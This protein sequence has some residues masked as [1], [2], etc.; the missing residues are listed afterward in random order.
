MFTGLIQ[1]VGSISSIRPNGGTRRIT[2][3]AP[4]TSRELEL[5]D[6]IAVS[7]VCLT[8]VEVGA[9]KSFSADLARETEERTSFLR[10]REGAR[11]NLEL[12]MQSGAR[13]GGHIVQG[14]V[15][16][17]GKLLSLAPVNRKSGAPG[18][19]RGRSTPDLG[20]FDGQSPD[21]WLRIAFPPTLAR[22]IVEKGSITIEGI[23]LTVAGVAGEEISIAIIPHTLANTNL[24]F[25]KPGDPLNI[26][27][28]VLAKY[29]E[30]MGERH[31]SSSLTIERLRREGF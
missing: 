21:Y 11:V 8:A 24:R 10:L 5:G 2:I 16:G 20:D 14:H 28:D 22:Y 23:S 31:A 7:G 1:E 9:G 4:L 12:P 17:V 19:G 13:L 6:S 18:P 25:L 30:G 27:V 15:D 26:E 29:A 3:A